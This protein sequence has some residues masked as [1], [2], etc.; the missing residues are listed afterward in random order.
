MALETT[1]ETARFLVTASADPT[2]VRAWSVLDERYTVPR[3]PDVGSCPSLRHDGV[4]FY[5]LTG[6]KDIHILRSPD[7]MTWTEST[8]NVL[9][10]SDV[11]DCIVA[12]SFFGPYFL[13]GVALQHLQ[14]CS[15]SGTFGDDSDV[16]LVEWPAPFGSST[17]GPA[18]LLEYGAGDQRTFGFS[19]TFLQ[20]FF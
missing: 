7:L 1:A 13:S 20:S 8:R 15:A 12:P 6:G 14:T 2:D 3:L 19:N 18:T 4:F 10:H 17:S 11:G 16:D 5:Y 9:T